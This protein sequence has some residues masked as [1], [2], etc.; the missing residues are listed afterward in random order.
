MKWGDFESKAEDGKLRNSYCG[1]VTD[2][3]HLLQSLLKSLIFNMYIV[4][5]EAVCKYMPFV[6]K[7]K[8]FKNGI[9]FY[10]QSMK[11]MII[12]LMNIIYFSHD[13]ECVREFSHV[14]MC[15]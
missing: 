8:T 4:R 1:K 14:Q 7:I 12:K 9:L 3:E 2:I 15:F 13:R 6:K 11:E 5:E 10:L